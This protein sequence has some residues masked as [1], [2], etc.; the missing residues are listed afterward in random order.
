M[1][2]IIAGAILAC[3]LIN[4][5]LVSGELAL[6]MHRYRSLSD[7]GNSVNATA[8][9]A[10]LKQ[11]S[12]RMDMVGHTL[13]IGSNICL[14][15]QG[16]L[17]YALTQAL[18]S[19]SEYSDATVLLIALI[20]AWICQHISGYI[21]PRAISFACYDVL[22]RYIGVFLLLFQKLFYPLLFFSDKLERKITKV[23]SS[24]EVIDQEH[25]RMEVQLQ[26]IKHDDVP[27][28]PVARKIFRNALKMSSLEISDVLL[29]RHQVH[30]MEL[31]D[32]L[33]E[34][35]EK[36]RQSGHTRFPLC[37]GG[38]DHCLGLIHIKDLFRRA[39]TAEKVNLLNIKRSI[40]RLS[41]DEPLEKA[42]EK[43]LRG[44][45]HMAL[46]VDEFG[47][48]AGVLTLENVLEELVGDIQDEF[49]ADETLISLVVRGK[50]WVS[51]LASI[52]DVEDVLGLDLG[53][54]DVSTFGGLI[55]S[56]LGRIPT[57]GETVELEKIGLSVKIE[58]VDERRVIAM[59]L[60]L[61]E[62]TEEKESNS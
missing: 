33:E 24:G 51:G 3:S 61:V 60:E 10:I 62:K 43:L 56:E 19:F 21:L 50:Y 2:Y 12:D 5:T 20:C 18:A 34:N 55:T 46:V 32:A 59:L 38:M 11:L 52:H 58:E 36:A 30:Y 25:L 37:R 22:L 1:E 57:K 31:N 53:N 29:P 7:T 9:P 48:V 6:F 49:D 54:Y 28:S 39:P 13:R 41:I 40:G 23:I 47:G 44:K 45:M 26:A 4:F 14:L 42:L 17:F 15:A 35:L 27:P 8:Q 16:V